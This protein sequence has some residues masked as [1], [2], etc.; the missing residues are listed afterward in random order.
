M[1]VIVIEEDP[2]KVF[3]IILTIRKHHDHNNC[4]KLHKEIDNKHLD[5][6]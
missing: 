2:L 6:V 3:D 1:S 5:Y 4:Q